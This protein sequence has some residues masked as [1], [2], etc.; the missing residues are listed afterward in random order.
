M[1]IMKSALI[2]RDMTGRVLLVRYRGRDKFTLPHA[3]VLTG[4]SPERAVMRMAGTDLGIAL[5]DL[6]L[7][8]VGVFDSPLDDGREG[9]SEIHLFTHPSTRLGITSIDFDELAWMDVEDI[10]KDEALDSAIFELLEK[11]LQASSIDWITV[12]TGAASGEDSA[13]EEAVEEFARTVV[14]KD[15]GVV[16]GAGAVGLMGVLADTVVSCGGRI[17]GIS[18]RILVKNEVPHDGL[19]RLEVVTDMSERKLRMGALGKAF[20]A[21]PGGAGTLEEFFE[22]WT[23]QQLGIHQKPV[24]L[25]NT[26]GYWDHL[27]SLI[28]HMI[29]N[30]FLS[31]AYREHLIVDDDP[32]AL[33]AKLMSWTPPPARWD[34]SIDITDD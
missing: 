17:I 33:L 20:V 3:T 21:L 11:D 32:E 19:T 28:D 30:G 34:D 13:F 16:F 27:L 10:E 25:L 5:T 6:S 1:A 26:K 22:V 24:A 31:S 23:W 8:E 2:L 9:P 14:R 18:P 29:A 4:E 15:I 7:V 12:Y